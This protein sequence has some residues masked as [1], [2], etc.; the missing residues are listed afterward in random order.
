MTVAKARRTEPLQAVVRDSDGVVDNVMV[1]D[2]ATADMFTDMGLFP[3]STLHDV[4]G[5]SVGIGWTWADDRTPAFRPPRPTPDATWND[6]TDEWDV[7]EP[8][9]EPDQEPASAE[10]PTSPSGQG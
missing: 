1:C 9:P 2:Q 7:P 3:T 8:E 4:T 5:L 10:E 6:D